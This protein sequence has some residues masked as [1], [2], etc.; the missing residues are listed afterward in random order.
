LF[1]LREERERFGHPC[2]DK[3][4]LMLLPN[5]WLQ[6]SHFSTCSSSSC[7]SSSSSCGI[8]NYITSLC[9]AAVDAMA[10]RSSEEDNYPVD[11]FDIQLENQS[12]EKLQ[13]SSDDDRKFVLCP[14]PAYSTFFFFFFLSFL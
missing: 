4:G 13:F 5:L 2:A 6:F 9:R 14:T 11:N 10:K 1:D 12:G 8:W 3:P 7:S